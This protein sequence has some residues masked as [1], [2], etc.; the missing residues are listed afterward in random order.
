MIRTTLNS[1]SCFLLTEEPNWDAAVQGECNILTSGASSSTK[2]EERNAFS[3]TP[4]T[5]LKFT[6]DLDYPSFVALQN[7]LDGYGLDSLGNPVALQPILCPFWPGQVIYGQS[8]PF[9]ALYSVIWEPGWATW[10][11]FTTSAG[12]GSYTATANSM[13]APLL[14]GVFDKIPV[15]QANTDSLGVCDFTF[16]E[17]GPAAAAL[18]IASTP[19][20][21]PTLHGQA[22]PIFTEIPQ[23]TVEAGGATVD[24]VRKQIGYTR[25][26]AQ[27]V[28][29]QTPERTLKASYELT[30][31]SAAQLL[32]LWLQGFGSQAPFWIPSGVSPMQLTADIGPTDT[33]L[34]VDNSANFNDYAY[35]FLQSDNWVA[36][37]ITGTGSGVVTVA[38]APGSFSAV[39]TVLQPLLFARFTAD[40]LTISWPDPGFANATIEVVELPP[41]LGSPSGETFG[42][43]IGPLGFVFYL[44]LI[45]DGTSFWYITSCEQNITYNGNVYTSQRVTHGTITERINLDDSNTKIDI[46]NWA[47]NPFS[48]FRGTRLW[49]KMTITILKVDSLTPAANSAESVFTGTIQTPSFDDTTI[50]IQMGGPNALFDQMLPRPLYQK[51]CNSILFDSQCGLVESQ[52]TFACTMAT[53]PT[54]GAPYQYTVSGLSWP[55]GAL[56]SLLA[57]YFAMGSLT[58]TLPDG[59]L[60]SNAIVD[61]TAISGGDVTLTLYGDLYPFPTGSETWSIVPGCDGQYSTCKAK[62]ANGLQFSGMPNMPQADPA[63]LPVTPT[64]PVGAKK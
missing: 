16:V 33:T 17:N 1:T 53:P 22:W 27:T 29:P 39:S 4:R 49:P 44:Y 41:E 37:R 60:Q 62:F 8:S 51:M 35:L 9:S 47:G 15:P 55:Q 46:R 54:P 63:I 50:S 48:K 38:A 6:S 3:S 2:R 25:D 28:Y 10:A 61:S 58:R 57:G 42:V 12:I 11:I 13:V 59:T 14:W 43:T 30:A 56:P 40:K 31:A 26:E 45:T 64:T 23:Y 19:N 24:I 21:G 32:A 5:T 52:W 18:T 20:I 36:A 7:S 34:N